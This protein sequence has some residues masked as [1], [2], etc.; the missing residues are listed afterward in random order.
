MHKFMQSDIVNTDMFYSTPEPENDDRDVELMTHD[1]NQ[2]PELIK[3]IRHYT[4]NYGKEITGEYARLIMNNM[5]K[6]SYPVYRIEPVSGNRYV[7]YKTCKVGDI[8]SFVDPRTHNIKSATTEPDCE[9]MKGMKASRGGSLNGFVVFETVGPIYT[10]SIDAY[11]D[12]AKNLHMAE[13]EEFIS[14]TFEIVDIENKQGGEHRIKIKQLSKEINA[15]SPANSNVRTITEDELS[16]FRGAT[17]L[18]RDQLIQFTTKE[19]RAWNG[20]SWWTS[21][22][23]PEEFNHTKDQMIVVHPSGTPLTSEDVPY[24]DTS[25]VIRPTIIMVDA[26]QIGLKT[27]DK[28]IFGKETFTVV[29]AKMALCDTAIGTRPYNRKGAAD[30]FTYRGS[31]SNQ[32]VNAWFAD[33]KN[34]IMLGK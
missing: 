15:D 1:Y 19:Q 20:G 14:G 30:P 29:N 17:I 6:K 5:T 23:V 27:G 33:R 8:F 3:A 18:S 31:S 7:N 26:S 9:S 10:L 34:K 25:I 16:N 32:L 21:Q 22:P 12:Y 4:T 2:I 28:F 24:Y 13:F 11:T